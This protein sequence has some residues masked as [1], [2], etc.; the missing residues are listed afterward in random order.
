MQLVL[1]RIKWQDAESKPKTV[2]RVRTNKFMLDF[3]FANQRVPANCNAKKPVLLLRCIACFIFNPLRSKNYWLHLQ[4]NAALSGK[5]LLEARSRSAR[6][7]FY[8]LR[9]FLL[10]VWYK[11]HLQFS[12]SV[13]LLNIRQEEGDYHEDRKLLF[14]Y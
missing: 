2:Y 4:K 3:R 7:P 5:N 8:R 10:P 14:N 11:R 13:S 6:M 9:Q 1:L 12:G